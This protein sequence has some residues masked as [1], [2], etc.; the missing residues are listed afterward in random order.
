M[1][2]GRP[3]LCM[4]R[5]GLRGS[6]D[7]GLVGCTPGA[8][9]IHSLALRPWCT[10]QWIKDSAP[11]GVRKAKGT[12]SHGF[13]RLWTGPHDSEPCLS[14]RGATLP[15]L[16]LSS[17]PSAAPHWLPSSEQVTWLC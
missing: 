4:R 15:C 1:G 14:K 2:V 16:S 3:A 10:R 5:R 17:S 12:D 8:S 13:P 9:L 11:M 7:P 6:T